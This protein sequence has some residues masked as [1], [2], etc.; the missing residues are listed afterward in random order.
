VH[1]R[2]RWRWATIASLS[3]VISNLGSFVGYAVPI[4]SGCNVA[5]ASSS[6]VRNFDVFGESEFETVVCGYAIR[7]R[8]VISGEPLTIVHFRILQARDREF[9]TAI[10]RGIEGGNTVNYREEGFYHLNLGCWQ[11]NRIVGDIDS[12]V[13]YLDRATQRTI[14]A[15]TRQKPVKLRLSFR[16]RLG[17]GC[18]CCNLASR[19]RAR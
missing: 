2:R 10:A 15:S 8:S 9:L 4:P 13:N 1:D 16:R 6:G 3:L 11:N 14:A 5:A 17:S 7:R 19:I 12:S 18:L